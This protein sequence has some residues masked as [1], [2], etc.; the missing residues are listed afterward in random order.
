MVV[1]MVD[2]L[3]LIKEL[4][5]VIHLADDKGKNLEIVIDQKMDLFPVENLVHWNPDFGMV[6]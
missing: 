4:L 5:K 6:E 1:E 2:K 3:E